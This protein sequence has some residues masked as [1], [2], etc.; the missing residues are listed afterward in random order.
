MINEMPT[1]QLRMRKSLRQGCPLS[2]LL[3]NCVVEAFSI[4][5]SEMVR[6]CECKGIKI[7]QNALSI[8]NLQFT[9]DTMIMCKLE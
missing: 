6:L 2:P 3:F 8:S 9:D 4:I 1:R 7:G 5:M